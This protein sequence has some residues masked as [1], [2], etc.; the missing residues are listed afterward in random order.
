MPRKLNVRLV[1]KIIRHILAEPL[2]YW[3]KWTIHTGT[4]GELIGGCCG[5]RFAKCG[6]VAC[7][8]GWAYILSTTRP[9]LSQYGRGWRGERSRTLLD[10]G[11]KAL[12]LSDYHQ[13]ILFSGSPSYDWPQPYAR[14]YDAATTSRARARVACRLLEKVIDTKAAIL[15]PSNYSTT[16]PRRAPIRCCHD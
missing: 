3:Q 13:S 8:G 4:P 2:R 11:G 7:I 16:R 6:T 9:R 5:Q 1:R 12:G 15:G 14:Q 10:K